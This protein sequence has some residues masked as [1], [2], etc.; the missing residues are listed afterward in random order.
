MRKWHVRYISFFAII[1]LSHI[2]FLCIYI[3][4]RNPKPESKPPP[5]GGPPKRTR[6]FQDEP[7]DLLCPVSLDSPNGPCGV[8]LP[9]NGGATANISLGRPERCKFASGDVTYNECKEKCRWWNNN[10]PSGMVGTT[11]LLPC[12]GFETT[13]ADTVSAVGECNLI[14]TDWTSGDDSL[15][16]PEQGSWEVLPLVNPYAVPDPSKIC[17][18]VR[19]SGANP[20]L[21]QFRCFGMFPRY[22][23]DI[24]CPPIPDCPRRS[25]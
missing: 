3:A 22:H 7:P 18:F 23:P 5:S 25:G 9:I 14:R 1:L 8:Y 11:N 10:P 16:C 4:Y 2:N 13:A 20:H 15:K 21:P 19:G 17:R 24:S 12:S 6:N